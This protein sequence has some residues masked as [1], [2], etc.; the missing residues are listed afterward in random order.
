LQRWGK[1]SSLQA[2]PIGDEPDYGDHRRLGD[3][4][5]IDVCRSAHKIAVW[6]PDILRRFRLD[7]SENKLNLAV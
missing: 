4:K 3:N 1:V 6:V 5:K 2:D 7:Y